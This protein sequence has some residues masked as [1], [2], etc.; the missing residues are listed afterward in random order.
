MRRS[1]LFGVVSD[2]VLWLVVL[3]CMGSAAWYG[4][5]ALPQS[6]QHAY[7]LTFLDANEMV[8][9]SNV[10]LMG[11]DIGSVENVSL[12]PDHVEVTVKTLPGV[13]PL[14]RKTMATI[15]FTGMVGSK[16]IE[17]LPGPHLPP[18]MPHQRE[19]HTPEILTEEPIRLRDAIQYNIDIAQAL[20]HGAENFSD[21]CRFAVSGVTVQYIV[22]QLIN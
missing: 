18:R 13:V 21:F 16:S 5:V 7:T 4:L 15:N 2:A 8:K 17:L 9:G 6:K 10:R 3:I 20:Q 11:V 14:P 19:R 12:S 22:E 1:Q